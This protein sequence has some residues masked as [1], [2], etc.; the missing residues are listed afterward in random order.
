M[1]QHT[2]LVVDDDPLARKIMA[3]QLAGHDVEFAE[4]AAR[5]RKKLAA[6]KPDLCF[7]DLSLGEGDDC[8][9]LDLI[10]L[11]AAQGAYSVVMS[12][13]DSEKFVERAYELGCDDFYSKGNEEL[14]VGSV[15]ARFRERRELSQDD[16]LFAA[17]FVTHDEESQRSIRE[18]MKYAASELPILILGPSGTGKTRLA[19]LIHDRSRRTGEFVAINCSAYTEDLLEAELFGYR[20]GAFTGAGDSRKGKLLLAD[21]GTL[22]LDE[23]GA[24]SLNMQ[25]KLLKAIEERQFYPLGSDRPETSRF[26]IVSATLE[27][28]QSLIKA[29]RMRFDFFQRIHGLTIELK[30]LSR[31]K[32]DVLPLIAHF[33]HGGRKL[34]FTA[35]A[36]ARLL[37]YAWPGNVRELKKFVELLSA[38]HEGRVGREAL[39]RLLQTARAGIAG[40]EFLTGEQYRLAKEQGLDAAVE[41]FIDEAVA[42]SLIE[43]SGMKTKVLKDLNI[44]TRLLY[45]S[46]ERNGR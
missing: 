15:L 41:L 40:V 25:T 39:D 32:D 22:F 6:T 20:K 38:G 26:R 10:P 7:I 18:A 34:G 19:K 12:G 46:L 27:D 29:G 31:R 13:H 28:L 36:K 1:D 17:R 23:I 44:S 42:R 9:G 4:D 8:S 14:N 21:K 11:A 33:T 45:A 2:I 24:M 43:N 16:R 35:E 30:P 37:E 3:A 5:A